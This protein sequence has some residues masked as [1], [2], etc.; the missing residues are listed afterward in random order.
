MNSTG[1]IYFTEPAMQIIARVDASSKTPAIVGPFPRTPGFSGDGGL[2]TEAEID[3]M[4]GFAM[5]AEGNLFLSDVAN[6]RVRRIDAKTGI[7][8]TV[9]G[10]GFP[11]VSHASN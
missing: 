10:N 4:W 6:Q 5:D 2:A 1:E 3:G 7:I 9:A 11:R 8:T